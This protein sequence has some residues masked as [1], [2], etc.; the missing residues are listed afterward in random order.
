MPTLVPVTSQVSWVGRTSV[1]RFSL[2]IKVMEVSV[3][4]TLAGR[5]CPCGSLAASTCPVS[6]SA[7]IQAEASFLGVAGTPGA[8]L[9]TSP[10]EA[11]WAPPMGSCCA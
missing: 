4:S 6:P 3:L 1:C 2:G 5:Y 7:M 11:S 8:G 9:T 10:R